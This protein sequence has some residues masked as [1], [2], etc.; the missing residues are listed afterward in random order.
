MRHPNWKVIALVLMVVPLGC[1]LDSGTLGNGTGSGGSRPSGAGG[2]IGCGDPAGGG[3]C[4]QINVPIAPLSP[5]ILIVQSRALSMADSWDNQPCQGGCG[6]NSKW[7]DTSNTVT[8][9]VGATASS[10]NWGLAF[11]GVSTCGTTSKPYV[12]LGPMNSQAISTAFAANQPATGNP[13]ETAINDAATYMRTLAD[14]N[15]K[16]LLLVTDGL[17]NCMPGDT[18]TT[19]DDSLG[20]EAAVLNARM[21]GVPT[22]VVGLATSSDATVTATLDQLALNGGEAQAGGTSSYFAATDSASLEQALTA[23]VGAAASCT[24]P[25]VDVP[26]NLTNVAVSAT[27]GS[28][29]NVKIRQ[30]SSD[31]WTFTDSREVA[32][33][34]NGA[35]CANLRS[36][37][38]TNFQFVYACDG[39]VICIDRGA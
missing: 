19:A 3:S 4:G 16:Y 2:A 8:A 21:A 39:V 28:G 12:P 14:P 38:Y 34:L 7:S 10:I 30:D 22:F 6:A 13:I 29:N 33:V 18:S 17:P 31:G 25:L 24:L 11:Y 1:N 27:D 5:D 26:L 15:P 35:T 23:I 37:A 32:I 36:G 9:A 20:A